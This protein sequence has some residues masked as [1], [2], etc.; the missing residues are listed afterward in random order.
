MKTF[1][2]EDRPH[3]YS[4]EVKEFLDDLRESGQ[5]NMFGA[6]PYLQNEYGLSKNAANTYLRHWQKT[7]G[8]R[9][10]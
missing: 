5:V 4:D 8:H 3:N 7:F 9:E 2:L 10:V 1:K 6:A